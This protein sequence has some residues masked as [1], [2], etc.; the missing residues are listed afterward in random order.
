MRKTFYLHC[1]DLH[2]YPASQV[3]PAFQLLHAAPEKKYWHKVDNK[4]TIVTRW[5]YGIFN[6]KFASG[7]SL[8]AFKSTA[9]LF[10][11]IENEN[12]NVECQKCC[13]HSWLLLI[14]VVIFCCCCCC[15]FNSSPVPQER[16]TFRNLP[17]LPIK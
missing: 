17:C 9:L 15:C 13:N 16:H 8:M 3:D 11:K 12:T 4:A 7:L 10:I 6:S 2:A 5:I 14:V 1:L